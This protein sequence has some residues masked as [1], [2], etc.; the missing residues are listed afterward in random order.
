[1]IVDRQTASVR[2]RVKSQT[3]FPPGRSATDGARSAGTV[4]ETRGRTRH[5]QN[6]TA[7]DGL[8]HVDKS[9]HDSRFALPSLLVAGC[10]SPVKIHPTLRSDVAG[11]SRDSDARARAASPLSISTP[12]GRRR[13][14]NS[15]LC[16]GPRQ[17]GVRGVSSQRSA[18]VFAPDHT[19]HD[20]VVRHAAHTHLIRP[21]T[22][23]TPRPCHG[24]AVMA[25]V[26]PLRSES[27]EIEPVNGS[28]RSGGSDR[29]RRMEP[30]S[31]SL[32]PRPS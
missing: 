31:A 30:R 7:D 14:G 27:W 1:M 26:R 3:S 28:R 4:H 11:R 25:P 19:R 15:R 13:H 21:P 23:R 18:G 8:S 24:F 16:G 5:E 22:P 29:S 17:R 2:V 6:H 20:T 9:Q 12:N 10:R 32:P